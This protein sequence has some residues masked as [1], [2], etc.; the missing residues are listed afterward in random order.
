[1]TVRKIL[2]A[3]YSPKV[4]TLNFDLSTTPPS[5]TFS[6]ALEVGHHPSWIVPHSADKS[7][8]FTATEE[9]NG[10]VKAL[11]YDL[12]TGVGSV[13]AETSS[14]GADPCHLAIFEN[15]LLVANVSI[16]VLVGFAAMDN[17]NSFFFL[18]STRVAY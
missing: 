2:V 15:E 11:K 3:T 10:T 7:I 13:V 12:E 1:M 18:F 9:P 4:F 8:V 5:L 17:P 16:L 6:S 14:G